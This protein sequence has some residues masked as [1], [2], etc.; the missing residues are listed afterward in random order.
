MDIDE[1]FRSD[2]TTP[3]VIRGTVATTVTSPDDDLY[4]TVQ[5]FDG[6]R[7]QWGP[8]PWSPSSALP[9]RGEDCLVLFDERETPWV[10]VT[11]R[12]DSAGYLDGGRPDSV[13]GGVIPIDGGGV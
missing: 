2:E 10:M 3:E 11:A 9:T 7:V 8:C 1:L 13:Y 6:G 5:A 4:V 12:L